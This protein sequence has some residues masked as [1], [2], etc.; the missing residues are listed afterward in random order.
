M[1]LERL[2]KMMR[3]PKKTNPLPLVPLHA[4][5]HT[6]SNLISHRGYRRVQH[7]SLESISL[8]FELQFILQTTSSDRM[9]LS[10]ERQRKIIQ[11]ASPAALSALDRT[12]LIRK[13]R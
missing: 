8:N 7:S 10:S 1:V 3:F 13:R 2:K 5:P 9:S 4:S 11:L 12:S 6:D